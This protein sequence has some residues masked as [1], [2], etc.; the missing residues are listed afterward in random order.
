MKHI[1]VTKN[2]EIQSS[3]I[4]NRHIGFRIKMRRLSLKI[5]LLELSNQV[6]VSYQQICKYESGINRI[7]ASRLYLFSKILQIDIKYFFEGCED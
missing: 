2:C 5:T 1:N 4:L 6:D 7:S 3:N